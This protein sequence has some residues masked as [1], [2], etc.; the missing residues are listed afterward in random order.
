[1]AQ[2]IAATPKR[3]ESGELRRYRLA[4][5]LSLV[6][7]LAIAIW[8]VSESLVGRA[9]EA[10]TT[11]GAGPVGMLAWAVYALSAV[12]ILGTLPLLLHHVGFS[13]LYRSALERSAFPAEQ[14]LTYWREALPSL[15]PACV[16][17]LA[18]LE[19]EPEKDAAAQLLR[20]EMQ[21]LIRIVERDG[22][23][24]TE[25]VDQSAWEVAQRAVERRRNR[26]AEKERASKGSRR[27]DSKERS[28]SLEA[29]QQGHEA[30]A[31]GFT[32]SDLVLVGIASNDRIRPAERKGRLAEWRRL[33][34]EAALE[35]PYFK[36]LPARK[37]RTVIYMC[38]G[39]SALLLAPAVVAIGDG[40]LLFEPDNPAFYRQFVTRPWLLLEYV[41]I[42]ALCAAFALGVFSGYI[43][44][45]GTA[46]GKLVDS[47]ERFV[48][49]EEG[50]RMAELVFG[51]KNYLRDFTL[52]SE[53]DRAAVALWDD[54]LVC[55]V[56]LE[57]NEHAAAQLLEQRGLA[58][59]W[60]RI[61]AS[62]G[63]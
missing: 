32:E 47:K 51:L 42:T 46:V 53:A 15:R 10:A 12:L 14:G 61:V 54:L 2:K 17:M 41:G 11:S 26:E 19:V 48:R 4:R 30:S 36:R 7:A 39:I 13:R 20:L 44:M 3:I 1:M 40:H 63:A 60:Q 35:T 5:G 34:E 37:D 58:T 28:V 52:L 43:G 31:Q 8:L 22:A 59:R 23:P 45:V 38:L 9:L 55:A 24:V 21:G 62:L 33:E 49:T 50:N 18:D 57:E 6:V 56:V 25:V 16:S 29:D 27:H